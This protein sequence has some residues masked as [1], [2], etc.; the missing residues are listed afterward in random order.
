MTLCLNQLNA[1]LS[2]YRFLT[3]FKI[4]KK[5]FMF[6]IFLKTSSLAHEVTGNSNYFNDLINLII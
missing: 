4:I 3:F 6:E 2:N 5:L 1:T